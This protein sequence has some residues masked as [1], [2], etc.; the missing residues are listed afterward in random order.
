[1]VTALELV[2]SMIVLALQSLTSWMVPPPPVPPL[3]LPPPFPPV[4]SP[5]PNDAEV[6]T[7]NPKRGRRIRRAWCMFD[8]CARGALWFQGVLRTAL[9]A[10][11]R[12]DYGL[13][14]L[15]APFKTTGVMR[16]VA[17]ARSP[18]WGARPRLSNRAALLRALADPITGAHATC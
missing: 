17:P 14:A 18:T 7:S 9:V 2:L 10:T 3:G 16:L 11:I 12:G 13:E 15:A 1:M 6:A 8:L 5:Q 4:S